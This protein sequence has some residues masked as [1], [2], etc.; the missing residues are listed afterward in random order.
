MRKARELWL[1]SNVLLTACEKSLR[2]RDVSFT[3]KK[4]QRELELRHRRPARQEWSGTLVL[5]QLLRHLLLVELRV[6]VGLVKFLL[7]L[8]RQGSLP[9]AHSTSTSRRNHNLMVPRKTKLTMMVMSR[10]KVRIR[11]RG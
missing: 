4:R 3:S 1:L 10:A 2:S 11:G 5:G 7:V 8:R 9:R 6:L